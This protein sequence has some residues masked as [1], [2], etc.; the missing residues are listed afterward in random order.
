MA[1]ESEIASLLK[2][3]RLGGP[4]QDVAALEEMVAG[5]TGLQAASTIEQ[6]GSLGLATEEELRSKPVGPAPNPPQTRPDG[7]IAGPYNPLVNAPGAVGATAKDEVI[8]PRARNAVELAQSR[9][10]KT[11]SSGFDEARN[12]GWAVGRD[13]NGE[14]KRIEAAPDTHDDGQSILDVFNKPPVDPNLAMDEGSPVAPVA[15]DAQDGLSDAQDVPVAPEIPS[16]DTDGALLLNQ[17]DARARREALFEQQVKEEYKRT[18]NESSIETTLR[19]LTPEQRQNFVAD[20]QQRNL[21][22]Q[23]AI[24]KKL[25]SGTPIP[26]SLTGIPRTEVDEFGR[27]VPNISDYDKIQQLGLRHERRIVNNLKNEG[28]SFEDII[29]RLN[30]IQSLPVSVREEAEKLE[31]AGAPYSDVKKLYDT[32]LKD[33]KD[34]NDAYERDGSVTHIDQ[35]SGAKFTHRP[36]SITASGGLF[37]DEPQTF[38]TYFAPQ[39]GRTVLSFG[40]DYNNHEDQMLG[41]SIDDFEPANVEASYFTWT[42]E[43]RTIVEGL[44]KKRVH[45][46]ELTKEAI[47][48]SAIPFDI[49]VLNEIYRYGVIPIAQAGSEF[50]KVGTLGIVDVEDWAHEAGLDRSL[51]AQRLAAGAVGTVARGAG[52]AA[53]ILVPFAG[54]GR[55]VR[56]GAE[57]LATGGVV[58]RNTAAAVRAAQGPLSFSMVNVG[59][60]FVENV[61]AGR[62]GLE[63]LDEA[64]LEGAK[65]GLLMGLLQMGNQAILR[66]VGAGKVKNAID[67]VMTGLEFTAI[68]D[69]QAFQDP[70]FLVGMLGGF[71]AIGALHK[72]PSFRPEYRP[73]LFNTTPTL[74]TRIEGRLKELGDRSAGTM[75]RVSREEF[76]KLTD[77]WTNPAGKPEGDVI[78]ARTM[79][80]EIVHAQRGQVDTTIVETIIDAVK[81]APSAITKTSLDF[82]GKYASKVIP[83]WLQSAG[84][85]AGSEWASLMREARASARAVGDRY[86]LATANEFDGF[87]T[88]TRKKLYEEAIKDE[89]PTSVL[90]GPKEGPNKSVDLKDIYAVPPILEEALR[91]T[92][93]PS[94][95]VV[96]DAK[97]QVQLGDN[98]VRVVYN[99]GQMMVEV[100]T[101]GGQTTMV[102]IGKNHPLFAQF[103]HIVGAHSLGGDAWGV[104]DVRFDPQMVSRLRAGQPREGETYAGA[105]KGIPSTKQSNSDVETVLRRLYLAKRLGVVDP[106]AKPEGMTPSETALFNKL[107]DPSTGLSSIN[108]SLAASYARGQVA[109]A[110]ASESGLG[111]VSASDQGRLNNIENRDADVRLAKDL[112]VLDEISS[113]PDVELRFKAFNELF[114][115]EA[116]LGRRVK[117]LLAG[118]ETY[119]SPEEIRAIF[120]KAGGNSDPLGADRYAINYV[121]G[122]LRDSP[123]IIEGEMAK[124]ALARAA[125]QNASDRTKELG[126]TLKGY[127]QLKSTGELVSPALKDMWFRNDIAKD[128]EGVDAFVHNYFTQIQRS[129]RTGLV[130]LSFGGAVRDFVNDAKYTFWDLGHQAPLVYKAS[131]RR[132]WLGQQSRLGDLPTVREVYQLRNMITGENLNK[133]G[134]QIDA[135][136]E[137]IAGDPAGLTLAQ[138][139]AAT[140]AQDRVAIKNQFADKPIWKEYEARFGHDAGAA[141]LRD[142]AVSDYM[143]RSGTLGTSFTDVELDWYDNRTPNIKNVVPS[144]ENIGGVDYSRTTMEQLRGAAAE[145]LSGHRDSTGNMMPL[146]EWVEAFKSYEPEGVKPAQ[147][148]AVAKRLWNEVDDIYRRGEIPVSP[149]FGDINNPHIENRHSLNERIAALAKSGVNL[150]A[151]KLMAL[152]SMPDNYTKGGA[153]LVHLMNGLSPKQAADRIAARYPNYDNVPGALQTLG[154]YTGGIGANFFTEDMRIKWNT[155]KEAPVRMAMTYLAPILAGLAA[156]SIMGISDREMEELKAKYGPFVIPLGKDKDGTR[157]VIDLTNT[158]N[159]DVENTII[160][161]LKGR[162]S[163]TFGPPGPMNSQRRSQ[164]IPAQG[165]TDGLMRI[166]KPFLAPYLEDNIAGNIYNQI[167]GV[168][169]FGNEIPDSDRILG[170]KGV[171]GSFAPSIGQQV[172]KIGEAIL[173]TGGSMGVDKTPAERLAVGLRQ[174]GAPTDAMNPDREQKLIRFQINKL[175]DEMEKKILKAR[176]ELGAD[177][178]KTRKQEILA[179]YKTLREQYLAKMHNMQDIEKENKAE[180]QAS[181]APGEKPLEEVVTKIAESPDPAL[182]E[183]FAVLYRDYAKLQDEYSTKLIEA[184]KSGTTEGLIAEYAPQI[185]K[186]L[187]EG[188]AVLF[189]QL[190][191]GGDYR[192]KNLIR[193]TKNSLNLWRRL[194]DK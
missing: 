60:R 136:R 68:K 33:I 59:E 5:L 189:E 105:I 131:G 133:V 67:N 73:D 38:T 167:Q 114:H 178:Y 149:E 52:T 177:E 12:V 188:D 101:T 65:D 89:P 100:K 147:Q 3:I 27:T 162:P 172:Y 64:A 45:L 143:F 175:N 19:H 13:A 43:A 137:R 39:P 130:G 124:E 15:P 140:P 191:K 97:R 95:S 58:A 93:R 166:L 184:K 41:E 103:A 32:I 66:G 31:L 152:R 2:K 126:K 71:A 144:T 192:T 153:F 102:E 161:T 182:Q 181:I 25:Q 146:K 11:V 141:L 190:D 46:E 123:L 72:P 109:K 129:V 173:G 80:N 107:S 187:E 165:F 78:A 98:Q 16:A 150:T 155:A 26:N 57:L 37:G 160:N 92:R 6:A 99:D 83:K 7:S 112:L 91:A 194:R 30:E 62:S 4:G 17:L 10:I 84:A 36:G 90:I 180:P 170:K 121:D 29:K 116:P 81:K 106:I 157:A 135:A 82:I 40:S 34:S 179:E 54:A 42:P 132:I 50:V 85:R 8:E 169:N 134:E 138:F 35:A 168:D 24:L 14:L 77:A 111:R 110:V 88:A 120:N 51:E 115:G 183:R 108:R 44:I 186:L 158:L 70:A 193:S 104:F 125:S 94:V 87:S 74:M 48:K 113:I 18:A 127:R 171:L 20:R 151:G 21:D 154:R 145:I 69:P 185:I 117:G 61:K 47:I 75:D 148:G 9:G 163:A 79:M 1:G 176:N 119:Y 139:K 159:L 96:P 164:G 76:A 174:L 53:G 23:Q 142:L 49:P 22:L 28:K 118:K 122:K 156:Q 56:G 86:T 55:V 63:Q 128:L